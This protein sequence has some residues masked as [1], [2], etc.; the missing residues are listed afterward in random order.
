MIEERIEHVAIAV[1][2]A[3]LV[4]VKINRLKPTDAAVVIKDWADSLSW[5]HDNLLNLAVK[6]GDLM[7]SDGLD[8]L[9]AAKAVY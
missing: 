8:S 2:A 1:S 7:I 3:L 9:E 4:A 6:A 5:T